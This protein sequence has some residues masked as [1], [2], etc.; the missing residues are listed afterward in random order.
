MSKQKRQVDRKQLEFDLESTLAE[1]RESRCPSKGPK[2][3]PEGALD[4]GPQVAAALHGALQKA[5]RD[6]KNRYM[7]AEEVSHLTGKRVTKAMLDNYV[8]RAECKTP[9]HLP[10]D[11][12]NALCQVCDDY[13][14]IRLLCRTS[15]FEAVE[16]ETIALARLGHLQLEEERIKKEKRETH[17]KLGEVL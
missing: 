1:I 13:G 6:G 16:A 4:M 2:S 5:A 12:V 15:K 17:R 8:S 3:L 7:V 11:L 14:L 10:A 9:Y